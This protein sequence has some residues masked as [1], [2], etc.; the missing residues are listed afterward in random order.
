MIFIIPWNDTNNTSKFTLIHGDITLRTLSTV[1]TYVNTLHK[2][3]E[4]TLKDKN[5]MR[6]KLAI[7]GRAHGLPKIHKYYQDI[8]SFRPIVDT[9][10]TPHYGIAKFL[11]S[12]LNPL[13]ISNYSVK[14]SFE[15]AKR[16]QAILLELFM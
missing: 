8:P 10:S 14:D 2:R 1:K 7:I 13:A 6:P 5:L 9:I 3:N 12:L 15:A 16:I 11:S 4:I